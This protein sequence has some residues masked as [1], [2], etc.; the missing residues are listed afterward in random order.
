MTN[1]ISLTARDAQILSTLSCRVRF[2]SIAQIAN[3]WWP[4]N[5]EPTTNARRRLL[6]L[7]AAG[8]LRIDSAFAKPIPALKA[9][10]VAWQPA[11]PP[12]D[13]G[14]ISYH[15]KHRFSGA[16][17]ATTIAYATKLAAVRY[18]GFSGRAPRRSEATHDL[19]LGQVYLAHLRTSPR[20]AAAWIPE[21]AIVKG[22]RADSQKVPDALLRFPDKSEVIIEF[23]GEYDKAK[24]TS[25]HLDCERRGRGYQLW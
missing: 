4:G 13:F 5:V 20:V 1:S 16:A 17:V 9:P 12:P 22:A 23:G 19:A 8:Y 10:L 3:Q 2:L 24:L 7:Q 11:Q 21:A 25:F 18:G 6:Q 14:I 15:L